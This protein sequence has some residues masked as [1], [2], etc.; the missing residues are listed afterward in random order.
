[1]NNV[2]KKS[3]NSLTV[4][5][6]SALDL[7]GEPVCKTDIQKAEE[8]LKLN[9]GIKYEP[10]KFQMLWGMILSRGW[11]AE[12]L[13]KTVEWFL[14]NKKFPNWTIADWFDYDVKIYPYAWY[15]EKMDEGYKSEDFEMYKI[16][17]KVYWKLKDGN[18]LPFEKVE[19]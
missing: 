10:A 14:M 15:L 1:M 12:R 11:S 13:K 7:I 2:Q 8:M 4:S 3:I 6:T 17:G 9:Y 19:L 16:D 18:E 5:G